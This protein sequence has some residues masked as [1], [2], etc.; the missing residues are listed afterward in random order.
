MLEASDQLAHAK[1]IADAW[2]AAFVIEKTP[3]A[4][5][6]TQGVL[7]LLERNSKGGDP[8]LH[9]AIREL[10]D[11]YRFLHP[12]LVFPQVFHTPTPGE[13]PDDA[14][15]GWTG[16]FDVVVGNPPWDQVQF[17]DAEFFSANGR[18]DIAS[19]P[20]MVA[21]KRLVATL[22]EDDPALFARY[23]TQGRFVDGLQS[24]LHGSGRFPTTS[25]GR[26]NLYSLF[27]ELAAGFLR[28]DSRLGMILPSGIAT[29]AF[30]QFF[31]SAS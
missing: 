13:E 20:T 30:N 22:E 10:A 14:D 26:L 11:R 7:E 3:E 27:A 5:V 4:P 16:G 29:D 23:Q 17:D 15:R 9:A 18:G 6:L 24:F 28:G 12:H 8:K 19:A 25:Y 31:S 2:C 21:R 1:L